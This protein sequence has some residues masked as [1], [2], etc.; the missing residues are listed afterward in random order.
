[1]TTAIGLQST[2]NTQQAVGFFVI[3]VWRHHL[4]K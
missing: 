2:P 3:L 1:M 4:Q